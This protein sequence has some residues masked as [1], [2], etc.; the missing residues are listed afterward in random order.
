MVAMVLAIKQTQ[1]NRSIRM[2]DKTFKIAG[3]SKLKGS[4]KVRFA[5]DMTRVKV[6]AKTGHSE[7]ELMELPREMTKPE[8]VTFLKTS[9]LYSR[10]EFKQAIDAADEKYNGSATVKVAGVKVKA[11]AKAKTSAVADKEMA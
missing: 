2:S 10:V 8:L 5:N 3:V 7:I 9:A 11:P 4:F 1:L 6:L